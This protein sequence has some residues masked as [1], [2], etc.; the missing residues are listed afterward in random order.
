MLCDHG[1][2]PRRTARVAFGCVVFLAV[3]HAA[4][5][6]EGVP[7]TP[8]P[9]GALPGAPLPAAGESTISRDIR[10]VRLSSPPVIDGD[11]SD[12]V[13]QGAARAERWVDW[14]NGNPNID[15]TVVFVGYDD[16]NLY[17]A[18]HAYDSQPQN[19]VARQTKRGAFP[20]GDDWIDLNLDLFH[21]HKFGDYC[22]FYVNP[23]GTRFANLAGGRAT[24]LEWEGDWQSAAKIV[25]DGYTVEMAI[26][27][28]SRTRRSFAR[29][30][31]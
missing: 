30:S 5:A 2:Y 9:S 25:A 11:L 12:P 31:C 4:M 1:K 29:A 18:W 28:A 6:A 7:T 17:L 19:I 15:Q 3:A 26:P 22:F 10:A 23:R 24:K 14:L 27:W 13:W 8:E 16:R 21:T 20:A